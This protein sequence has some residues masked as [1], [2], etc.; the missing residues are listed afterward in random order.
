MVFGIT[1]AFGPLWILDNSKNIKE[2][3][4]KTIYG[5]WDNFNVWNF[6]DIGQQKRYQGAKY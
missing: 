5:V 1:L 2:Q 4:I 6:M 3:S